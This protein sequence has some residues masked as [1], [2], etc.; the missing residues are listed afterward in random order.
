VLAAFDGAGDSLPGAAARL[1]G[2]LAGAH[3]VFAPTISLARTVNPNIDVT[4][5]L[6]L[7]VKRRVATCAA[8]GT[9]NLPGL[10]LGGLPLLG[11]PGDVPNPFRWS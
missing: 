11:V 9:T 7:K 1:A 4:D 6:P 8:G 5:V 10:A 3:K 2:S